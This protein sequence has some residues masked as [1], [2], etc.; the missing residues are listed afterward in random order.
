MRIINLSAGLSMYDVRTAFPIGDLELYVNNLPT[1][2]GE[3]RLITFVNEKKIGEYTL[4]RDRHNITIPRN[5]LSAGVFSCYVSQYV[6]DTEV[7]RYNVENLTITELN[8]EYSVAPEIMSLKAEITA[9][10]GRIDTLTEMYNSA[11]KRLQNAEETLAGHGKFIARAVE[12]SPYLS[13]IPY[14]TD[15][16]KEE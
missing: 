1:T 9:L 6:G 5:L 13:D 16:D 2:S 14:S 8:S 12:A 15:T 7:K 3:L 10:N 11:A 4:S